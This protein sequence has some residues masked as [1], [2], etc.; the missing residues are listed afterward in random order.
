Y[1][2]ENNL[3]CVFVEEDRLFICKPNDVSAHLMNNIIKVGEVEQSTFEH[4]TKNDIYQITPFI[5]EEHE[6]ELKTKLNNSEITRWLPVF[7]DV[8]RKGTD[9]RNGIQKVSELL[10]ISQS[11]IM[12][13][14]DG[15]NDISMLSY[16]GLSIAM[17][18]SA[19]EVKKHSHY[20]TSTPEED[21][22]YKALQHFNM[23]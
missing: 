10:N 9:K 4:S 18:Q 20:V 16:A 14:G 3:A 1:C 21:G 23:I 7:A 2:D 12:A 17:G 22:I 5:T 13:F 15:G 6:R 19:D 8:T 11:E